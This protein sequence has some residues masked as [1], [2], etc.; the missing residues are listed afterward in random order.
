MKWLVYLSLLFF[1]PL[2]FLVP[3]IAL[4]A[5]PWAPFW[6][7]QQGNKI[8]VTVPVDSNPVGGGSTI[9]NGGLIV[10]TNPGI[11]LE[12]PASPPAQHTGAVS[13]AERYQLISAAGAS[14]QV[15]IIMTALSIAEDGSGNPSIVSAPNVGLA[16]GTVDIGLW[17][18]NSA[19]VGQCGITS[20]TWLYDPMNNA[21]A[22]MCILGPKL[23]YCAW[24]TYEAS[25]GPGHNSAYRAFIG[26]A[27]AIAEGSACRR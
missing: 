4:F 21:R 3:L 6:F 1:A 10:P 9:G 8:A 17:Q 20:Q 26:C 24:S 23:N 18:V 16:A 12:P 2:L 15:A 11:S 19:H 25:C 14:P 13:D 22:A 5:Q 27:T 7:G